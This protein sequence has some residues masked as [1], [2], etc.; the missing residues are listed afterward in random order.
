M[1]LDLLCLLR[2]ARL[3]D[4]ALGA[5]LARVGA[6]DRRRGVHVRDRNSD[7]LALADDDMVDDLALGITSRP[8]QWD[9]VV[10]GGLRSVCS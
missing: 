4:P 8:R 5:E 1:A 10:L 3:V 7:F 9:D 6:P 2:Q